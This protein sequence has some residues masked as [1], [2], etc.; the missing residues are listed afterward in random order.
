MAKTALHSVVGNGNL[1]AGR[2]MRCSAVV[3]DCKTEFCGSAED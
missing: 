3:V 2:L 1:K